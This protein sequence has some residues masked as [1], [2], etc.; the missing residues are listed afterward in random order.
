VLIAFGLAGALFVPISAVTGGAIA[1]VLSAFADRESR[2]SRRSR[3]P[4][5]S[6]R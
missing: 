4:A 2:C 5:C 1:G 3:R 6:Q